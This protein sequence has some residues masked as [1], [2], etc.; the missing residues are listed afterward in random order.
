MTEPQH[1]VAVQDPTQRQTL[2]KLLSE[3]LITVADKMF[4]NRDI[5]ID[6]YRFINS[7]F[8]N[9]KLHTERGTFEF[10]HCML[11]GSTRILGEDAQKSV[12]FY[13]LGLPSLQSG[14]AFAAQVNAD[15]TISIGKGVTIQ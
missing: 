2:H 14:P 11:R 12:Q 1:A 10:H 15:G 13:S 7:S 5:Y 9:C 3:Y 6:G 4:E 8:V